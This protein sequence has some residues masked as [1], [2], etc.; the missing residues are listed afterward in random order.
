M[1]TVQDRHAEEQYCYLTT[2][3]RKS[4]QPH[5]IEIWFAAVG[6]SIYLMNGGNLPGGS[7]W[8]RN[9]RNDPVATVR[10]ADRQY[11]GNARFVDFDSDE[12]HE[13]R[14]LLVKK[15]ERRPTELADWAATAYPVVI[16]L[17][18]E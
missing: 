17:M 13:A 1:S 12:H 8:I 2:T 11:R 14:R 9:L 3:G 5:E 7:D 18:R 4:G 16:D 6:N 15:Y 10:I